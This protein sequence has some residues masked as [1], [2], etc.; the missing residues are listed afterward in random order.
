MFFICY[1]PQLLIFMERATAVSRPKCFLCFLIR[2]GPIPHESYP[3]PRAASH[4][5]RDQSGAGA[6]AR[7][8]LQETL[9]GAPPT[10]EPA[11]G[12]IPPCTWPSSRRRRQEL[13]PAR[14]ATESKQ[15]AD[16]HAGPPAGAP[17]PDVLQPPAGDRSPTSRQP[18]A[19]AIPIHCLPRSRT[20]RQVQLSPGTRQPPGAGRAA[21]ICRLHHHESRR[22]DPFFKLR[23][24]HISEVKCP[25]SNPCCFYELSPESLSR[26]FVH[27]HC[28]CPM[29]A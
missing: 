19:P 4:L 1:N 5:R 2:S 22:F 23:S 3:H 6:T 25:C 21:S 24:G 12:D 7:S 14:R 28:N 8:H 29:R 27:I 18:R 20:S 16:E 11:A 9:A 13:H 15:Q 26:N 10:R 17:P